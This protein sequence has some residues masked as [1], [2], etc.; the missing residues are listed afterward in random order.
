M[1]PTAGQ[2]G[3]GKFEGMT[4]NGKAWVDDL[5]QPVTGFGPWSRTSPFW[6]GVLIALG[7]IVCVGAGLAWI[8]LG[9]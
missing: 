3:T 9:G 4:W 7:A 6:R 2:R 8:A 5:G 1:T